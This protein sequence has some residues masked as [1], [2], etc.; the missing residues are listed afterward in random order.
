M[1]RACCLA[2]LAILGGAQAAGASQFAR[3]ANFVILADEREVAEAALAKAEA[4]RREI[5]NEWLGEELPPGIGAAMINIELSDSDESGLTWARDTDSAR[6]YHR[7]WLTATR[8]QALGG[9]LKH[10]LA[11]VVLAT[12]FPQ[13]LPPWIDEGI[14]SR[15]DDPGRSEIRRRT[16]AWFARSGNWPRLAHVLEDAAIGADDLASYAVAASLTEFLCQRGDKRTL[17]RFAR[18]GANASWDRALADCYSIESAA[19]LQQQWQQWVVE[20]K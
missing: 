1:N 11:H 15:Y 7:V 13:R 16:V 19:E 10:E 20:Q 14:A 5:A 18:Q 8:Q 9:V 3:N 17:L 6:K 2:V 4:Y 12:W